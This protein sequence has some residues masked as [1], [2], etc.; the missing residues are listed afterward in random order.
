MTSPQPV[1]NFLI[2]VMTGPLREYESV[3]VWLI[4]FC[5]MVVFPHAIGLDWANYWA[6]YI[7]LILRLIESWSEMHVIGWLIQPLTES[8]SRKLRTQMVLVSRLSCISFI[9]VMKILNIIRTC[10]AE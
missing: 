3:E 4:N 6:R 2:W 7:S 5:L 1:L 9:L 8:A 10:M